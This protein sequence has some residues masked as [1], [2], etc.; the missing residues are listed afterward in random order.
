MTNQ[1]PPSH[2]NEPTPEERL[3]NAIEGIRHL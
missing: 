3:A 1:T 2:T